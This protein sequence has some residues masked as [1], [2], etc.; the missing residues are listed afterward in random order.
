MYYFLGYVKQSILLFVY[1]TQVMYM[2]YFLGHQLM[3]EMTSLDVKR[4]RAD[5]TFIL[6][7]DGGF[8]SVLL[9]AWAEAR[10]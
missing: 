10:F 2:Y 3:S 7:L 6:A 8:Q 1:S 4:V 9:I 5:H